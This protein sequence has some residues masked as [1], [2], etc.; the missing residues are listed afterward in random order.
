M[1]RPA[2]RPGHMP[3]GADNLR[4][5]HHMANRVRVWTCPPVLFTGRCR[6]RGRPGDTGYVGG[7]VMP[8]HARLGYTR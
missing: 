3:G 8:W 6:L 7:A 1:P 5:M 2:G 4:G